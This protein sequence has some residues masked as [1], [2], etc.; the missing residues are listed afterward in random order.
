[1]FTSFFANFV[2]SAVLRVSWLLVLSAFFI[3]AV[4]LFVTLIEV[5]LT[6]LAGFILIPFAL[7]NKT[8]FLA[9]K[10]LGNIVAS[11][12]KVMVLAVIVGIGTG[13]FSQFTQSYA[14]GQ[15]T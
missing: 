8:A 6:T 11:G 7:F 9:E 5:K 14:G 3:L 1:G 4:Q 2:Q 13:L 15:P 10:V 12:V